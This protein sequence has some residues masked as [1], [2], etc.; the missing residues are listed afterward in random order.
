[1]IEI[2]AAKGIQNRCWERGPMTCQADQSRPC[3]ANHLRKARGC[4]DKLQIDRAFNSNNLL[5]GN[6]EV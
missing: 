2:C 1:M 5:S 6:L 3:L 4:L